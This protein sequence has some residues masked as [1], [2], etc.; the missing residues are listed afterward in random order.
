MA[1][2]EPAEAELRIK[3][4]EEQARASP[5]LYQARVMGFALLGFA[6]YGGIVFLTL[7]VLGAVVTLLIW[8]HSIVWLKLGWKAVVLLGGVLFGLIAALRVR[9]TPPVGVSLRRADVP[10]LFRLLDALAKRFRVRPLAHVILSDELNAAVSQLPRFGLFGETNTL[11]LGMPL[12]QALSP[13]DF[14][15]VLAHEFCHLSRNHSRQGAWI[16]RVVRTYQNALDQLGK[17][18]PIA[19]F[20]SWYV[21]RLDTLSFPLRRLNEYEADQGSVEVV[22]VERAAQALVNVNVRASAMDEFWKSIHAQVRKTEHPP[23]RLFEA[24][25]QVLAAQHPEEARAVLESALEEG[26][27]ALDTHPALADRL[28][29]LAGFAPGGATP[30]AVEA[31][32]ERTAAETYLGSS[33]RAL[34]S[35]AGDH[36]C[37]RIHERWKVEHHAFREKV[38]RL[39]KLEAERQR[40]TLDPEEAFTYADLSEDVHPERDPTPLFRALVE[41]YPEHTLARFSLARVLLTRDDVSGVP[42]M[43]PFTRDERLDLRAWSA[44]HLAAFHA[45]NQNAAE[46]AHHV[47][48]VQ[49]AMDAQA[50]RE[51]SL[52]SVRTSDTFVP[53][54]LP[55]EDVAKLSADLALFPEVRCAYLVRKQIDDAELP[56]YVVMLDTSFR[57]LASDEDKESLPSRVV[58]ALELPGR[59]TVFQFADN[60]AFKKLITKADGAK[61]FER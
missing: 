21:P 59:I 10:E 37:G 2:I 61:V 14:K 24:W 42:M 57:L 9:W 50:E 8:H 39:E 7:S 55:A 27:T 33:Y 11:V 46:L 15:S 60:R 12:L 56:W 48:L 36:W 32:P 41:R 17:N 47:A 22:G 28:R 1:G 40:R 51:E 58:A 45:R 20:L 13:D 6:V 18:R 26:T 35:S 54:G 19:R 25:P 5:G 49:K 4:Y 30:P 34:V 43:E 53:H 16:Y 3:R 23:A 38:T 52:Q 31:L 44:R 29:A